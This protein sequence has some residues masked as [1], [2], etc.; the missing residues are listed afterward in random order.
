V[1]F[2][3]WVPA[4]KEDAT[5]AFELFDADNRK[6]AAS[7]PKRTRL[8][9]GESFVQYWG[10]PLATLKAG[11]HRVDVLIGVNPVWRTFFVVTD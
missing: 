6:L 5:T 10:V 4:K 2:L 9:E 7:E 11:I 8:R 1:V 3:T